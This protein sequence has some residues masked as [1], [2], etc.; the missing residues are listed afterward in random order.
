MANRFYES[1]T[2]RC[3]HL[4]AL[5]DCDQYDAREKYNIQHSY[6][7]SSMFCFLGERDAPATA[8]VSDVIAKSYAPISI[9]RIE[10]V[11]YADTNIFHVWFSSCRVPE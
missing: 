1:I 4:L 2:V 8:Y 5:R 11:K 7:N 3:I 6:R 10:A 9:I